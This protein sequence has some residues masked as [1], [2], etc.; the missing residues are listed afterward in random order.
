MSVRAIRRIAAI[1][2]AASCTVQSAQ[3]A[4]ALNQL[5]ACAE[6]PRYRAALQGTTDCQTPTGRL[7]RALNERTRSWPGARLCFRSA[8]SAM[9]AG[10]ACM[11]VD[12]GTHEPAL[13]CLRDVRTVD[14]RDYRAR[15]ALVY[16]ALVKR[17]LVEASACDVG[18]HDASAMA[19]TMMPWIV[20]LIAEH[21]FG[22]VLPIG[23]R[24]VG[25][26][27]LV[28]GFGHLDPEI[29]SDAGRYVEYVYTWSS[30]K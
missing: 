16:D 4:I 23:P 6:L 3:G 20:S 26:S 8:P 19:P 24:L 27:T 12:T 9:L 1:G 30:R 5:S 13:L 17:Y 15:Y 25:S 11:N 10:F 22:F 21:D 29:Y 28:H 14:I 2:L 18:N 7:A